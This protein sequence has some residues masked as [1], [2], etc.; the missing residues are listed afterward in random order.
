[1][2]GA[3]DLAAKAD[4]CFEPSLAVSIRAPIFRHVLTRYSRADRLCHPAA[5]VE[6]FAWSAGL[7]WCAGAICFDSPYP[8]E[9]DFFTR[10]AADRAVH[11]VDSY[12]EAN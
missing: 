11:V 6:W 1:M 5:L 7:M 4:G 10:R 2:T 8:L 12:S 9:S 3:S